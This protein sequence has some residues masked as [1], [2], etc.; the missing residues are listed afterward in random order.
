M[1]KIPLN[2]RPTILIVDDD[3]T[4]ATV[5]GEAF[6]S[7]GFAVRIAHDVITGARLA[8]DDSPEYAVVDLK[9]PGASGLELVKQ[10]HELD[11]NTRVLVLTGYAAVAT[12]IEAI[13][14]GAIHYLAK[15][16][17]T[18]EILIALHRDQ[19]NSRIEITQQPLSVARWE[20]EY[21]QRI[22]N[23]CQG[24][25]SATARQLGMHRRT[26]QRKLAKRPSKK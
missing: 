23:E 3:I 20:W 17:N 22:L 16:A 21:I 9:M 12:A 4:F 11:N 2:E 24:N 10:L 15:P 25:I 13:K 19:G 8:A 14:L 7:R 18:D 6:E 5:L 26:L 1:E